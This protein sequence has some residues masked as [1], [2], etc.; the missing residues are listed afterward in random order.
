MLT[1]D[2]TPCTILQK[3]M[4]KSNENYG[5]KILLFQMWGKYLEWV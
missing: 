2:K 5:F 4:D 1:K 3:S